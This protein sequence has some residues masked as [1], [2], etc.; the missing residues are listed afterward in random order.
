MNLL[1]VAFGVFMPCSRAGGYQR[2]R[3]MCHPEGG[4][5]TVFETLVN[6][7]KVCYTWRKPVG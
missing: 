1:I 4:D 7:C 5:D 2:F 3:G 6:N